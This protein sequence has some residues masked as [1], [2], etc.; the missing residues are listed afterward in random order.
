M[1]RV[2]LYLGM[3]TAS[4]MVMIAK[5]DSEESRME[6]FKSLKV[7]MAAPDFTLKDGD[8]VDRSLRDYLGMKNIVLAFYPN[9]FTGG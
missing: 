8:G 7:G 6:E 4:F 3:I 1:Y 5:A 2:S 9:D